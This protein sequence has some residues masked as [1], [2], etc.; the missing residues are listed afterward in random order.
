[1]PRCYGS[2]D[3][4]ARVIGGACQPVSHTGDTDETVLAQFLLPAGALRTNGRLEIYTLWSFP[5]STNPKTKRIKVGATE[6]MAVVTNGATS[7]ILGRNTLI[8]ARG[9]TSQISMAKTAP[10]GLGAQTSAITT[11]AEDLDTELTVTI[12]AQ[13]GNSGETIVLEAWQAVLLNP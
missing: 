2:K 6:F 9:R 10:S 8:F 12:T 11:G 13:L 3:E 5:G 4:D 1:M 7:V